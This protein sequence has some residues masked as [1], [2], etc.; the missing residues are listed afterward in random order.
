MAR[1][2]V[3]AKPAEISEEDITT[4]SAQVGKDYIAQ[5]THEAPIEQKDNMNAKSTEMLN[6][7]KN[8][9]KFKEAAGTYEKY[10]KTLADNDMGK[11]NQLRMDAGLKPIH[12]ED[13]KLMPAAASELAT[14]I[15]K[16]ALRRQDANV[17]W[18][19]EI[20]KIKK[21]GD[22]EGAKELEQIREGALKTKNKGEW[23]AYVQQQKTRLVEEGKTD[24]AASLGEVQEASNNKW[25]EISSW[26]TSTELK[27]I[28]PAILSKTDKY[29]SELLRNIDEYLKQYLEKKS[30]SSREE[31]T[32]E[33]KNELKKEMDSIEEAKKKLGENKVD[34][35]LFNKYLKEEFNTL[36]SSG[37]PKEVLD[38]I[39]KM[40]NKELSADE[41]KL[42][43][44][45]YS[46]KLGTLKAYRRAAVDSVQ[47]M[48]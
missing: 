25:S 1:E 15:L 35:E 26:K 19:K 34:D 9:D 43:N 14:T 39:M 21:A 18:L 20:E 8:E 41:L 3:E 29:T 12:V 17:T 32:E 36:Q 48:S 45:P 44:M 5:T 27:N 11:F 4:K 2:T 40:N 23:D 46:V 13:P 22:F 37:A 28:I 38:N 33:E 16:E 30:V 42:D 6:D 7:P 10:Y 24:L 31:I 47:A